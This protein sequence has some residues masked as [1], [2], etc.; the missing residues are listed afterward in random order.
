MTSA[1][2]GEDDGE[3]EYLIDFGAGQNKWIHN[4]NLIEGQQVSEWYLKPEETE[5]SPIDEQQPRRLQ[6]KQRVPDRCQPLVE[7]FFAAHA[8]PK[9]HSTKQWRALMPK[10]GHIRCMQYTTR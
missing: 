5:A 6:H 7:M 2:P 3:R 8:K 1:S 10:N 9:T 4:E